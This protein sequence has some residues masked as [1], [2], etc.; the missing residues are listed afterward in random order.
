MSN[1]SYKYIKVSSESQ[2]STTEIMN[3]SFWQSKIWAEIL[4][5]T[6]QARDIILA[7]SGN[8]EILIER[9]SIFRNYCGLYILGVHPELITEAFLD[10]LKKEVVTSNDLFLQIEPI[11]IVN[12]EL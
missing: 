12:G 9:R 7:T 5:K 6:K 3:K 1:I 10:S 8:D 4:G 2:K 11:G